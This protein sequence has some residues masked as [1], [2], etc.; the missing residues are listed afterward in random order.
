MTF[1]VGDAGAFAAT[2]DAPEA[3]VVNPPRRGLGAEFADS[4]ERSG[5]D[6]VVYSSCNPV[7][8]ARDLREM[9]SYDVVEARLFDMFPQTRHAEVMTLLRRR[10]PLGAQQ[11][12]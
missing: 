4:L 7:T 12:P 8:L 6:T 3:I 11:S 1:E 5:P 10:E 9:P 2:H